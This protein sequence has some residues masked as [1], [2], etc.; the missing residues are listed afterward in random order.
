MR[1]GGGVRLKLLEA[2]AMEVPCVTTTLGAEGVEDFQPGRHALVA[3]QPHDFA[4]QV[5]RLL[6]DPSVGQTLA[7][8]G[9]RLVCEQYDWAPIVEQMHQAWARHLA[10]RTDGLRS[11]GAAATS[12]D[13][14]TAPRST[15]R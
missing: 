3:D 5:A 9:R 8:A 1:V 2:W 14:P 7:A 6:G 13:Q 15:P 10:L 11:S 4:A 12:D